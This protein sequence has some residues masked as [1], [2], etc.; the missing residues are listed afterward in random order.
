MKRWRNLAHPFAPYTLLLALAVAGF[1]WPLF[2]QGRWIPL[3][4]G[5]LASF[6]WPLYRF[7]AR[8]FRTG[9]IP[10]WNPYLYNRTGTDRETVANAIIALPERK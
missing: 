9:H 3:G 10:L 7:A 2:L 5:D 8:S 6:L 1:F 4:G